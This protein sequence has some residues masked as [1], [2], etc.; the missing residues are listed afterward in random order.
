MPR[1]R[2]IGTVGLPPRAGAHTH[3]IYDCVAHRESFTFSLLYFKPA[4][5]NELLTVA[6]VSDI[7]YVAFNPV[8]TWCLKGN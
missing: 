1:L 4:N 8:T 3:T 7:A 6:T 5:T 2:M